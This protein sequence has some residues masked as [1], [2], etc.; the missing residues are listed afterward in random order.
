MVLFTDCLVQSGGVYMIIYLINLSHLHCHFDWSGNGMEK[1][2]LMRAFLF[3]ADL[4]VSLL[5][6]VFI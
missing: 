2:F 1:S 6:I 4:F 3:V 5:K